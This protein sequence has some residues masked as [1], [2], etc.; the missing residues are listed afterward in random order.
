MSATI[1]TS[2]FSNYFS[3]APVIEV[4]GRTFP[5][6]QV[7]FS[8]KPADWPAEN[9][10]QYFLEDI[11]QILNFRPSIDFRDRK[12]KKN[13]NKNDDDDGHDEGQDGL[14]KKDDKN[15]NLEVSEE[16]NPQT[17][18]TVASLDEA[19]I[20]YDLMDQLLGYIK[21][22]QMEGSVLV[23]L[24]GWN[25]IHGLMK[26]FKGCFQILSSDWSA[27]FRNGFLKTAHSNHQFMVILQNS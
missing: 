27:S 20:N 1:D 3:N 23:F 17:R 9:P 12:R 21:T 10:F 25:T 7:S 8:T 16:Y 4:S 13:K 22:L 18:D 24:P 26:H 2:T 14:L 15:C 5:V 11:V 6:N 19:V